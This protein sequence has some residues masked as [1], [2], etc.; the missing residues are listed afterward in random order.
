MSD[1]TFITMPKYIATCECVSLF[2]YTY[3]AVGVTFQCQDAGL[4][5][6]A[7]TQQIKCTHKGVD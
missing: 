3:V 6:S 4:D 7:S 2:H 5:P 1:Q